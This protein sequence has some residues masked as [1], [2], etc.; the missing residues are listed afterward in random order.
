MFVCMLNTG[1]VELVS[2]MLRS[3]LDENEVEASAHHYQN[4][5]ED[6]KTAYGNAQFDFIEKHDRIPGLPE[7]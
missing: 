3:K 2:G 5:G 6:P 1:C 4:H 7:H